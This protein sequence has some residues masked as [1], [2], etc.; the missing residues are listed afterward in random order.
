ML[1]WASLPNG[2]IETAG[3][4]HFRPLQ[5]VKD[6]SRCLHQVQ[7][8]RRK[9]GR[10]LATLLGEGLEEKLDEDLTTFKQVMETGMAPAPSEY[11]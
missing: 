2:D 7:P 4:V 11:R 3:S 1:A 10:P 8:A 9:N 6:R 5:T